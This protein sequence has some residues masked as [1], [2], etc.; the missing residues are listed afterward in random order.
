MSPPSKPPG[1][2]LSLEQMQ[3]VYQK[4]FS[5]D[6]VKRE[7]EAW[8]TTQEATQ[9]TIQDITPGGDEVVDE[10]AQQIIRVTVQAARP[11]V[12]DILRGL[13]RSNTYLQG[14]Q[15]P[16]TVR[17]QGEQTPQEINAQGRELKLLQIPQ[18]DLDS[19]RKELTQY[20]VDFAVV[21][22]ES[23]CE[24]LYKFQDAVQIESAVQ[25]V[26]HTS[27][28]K[29][30]KDLVQSAAKGVPLTDR[31][32]AAGKAAA[33]RNA[34]MGQAQEQTQSHTREGISR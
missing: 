10:S 15:R 13:L 31:L 4:W 11:L 7:F 6:S 29:L 28:A 5:R 33:E 24:V 23:H 9:E 27:A 25:A 8:Q 18:Q 12:E 17:P 21:P 20:G 2:P 19:L 30:G 34:A 32:A 14:Q 16:E 26:F 3:D 1:L 22:R